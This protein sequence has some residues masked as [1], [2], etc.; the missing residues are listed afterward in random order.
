NGKGK[1]TSI[2]DPSGGTA[3]EYDLR[4]RVTRKTQT[5]S[6]L[7][8][9]FVVQYHYDAAGRMDSLTFPS[10]TALNYGFDANGRVSDISKAATPAIPLITSAAYF[11]FGAV[12]TFMFGNN[13]AVIRSFDSDGRLSGYPLSDQTRA[14]AYDD[15][16]RLTLN[17]KPDATDPRSFDYDTLDRLTSYIAPGA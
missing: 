16:S 10:G 12:R 9:P 13:Q 14:L 5:V 7:V 8:A 11:P 4:G 17:Q 6:G 15:G 1:L 2:S 3:W